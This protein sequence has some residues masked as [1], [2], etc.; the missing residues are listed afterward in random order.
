MTQYIDLTISGNEGYKIFLKKV[1]GIRHKNL[2]YILF[3]EFLTSDCTSNFYYSSFNKEL[4]KSCGF[5]LE[6]IC[7]CQWVYRHLVAFKIY[8]LTVSSNIM[9]L[10]AKV[11]FELIYF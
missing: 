8:T 10:N 1:T 7:K 4:D 3:K 6:N 9:A 11:P 2:T 5:I